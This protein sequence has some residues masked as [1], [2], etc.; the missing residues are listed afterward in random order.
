MNLLEVKQK[1]LN[2]KE[3]NTNDT[4]TRNKI[5]N[6]IEEVKNNPELHEEQTGLLITTE[7]E[8]KEYVDSCINNEI[9]VL[10]L[11]TTGLDCFSDAIVGVCLYTPGE[12]P[13]YI[14]I[15]HTDIENVRLEGQLNED[16]VRSEITR[17]MA[18]PS[19]FIN[20]NIKFDYKFLSKVWGIPVNEEFIFWDTQIGAFLL[21]ENEPT[22]GL[23][24]LYDKYIL[25][26]KATGSKFKDL[27]GNIPFNYIP[28]DIAKVYGAND[29]YKTY[30]LYEFQK[31][32]LDKDHP[33]A[34][35]QKLSYVFFEIEMKLLP[36]IIDIELTGIKLD[37]VRAKE[38][39]H[40]YEGKLLESQEILDRIVDKYLDKISKHPKLEP[41]IAKTGFNLNSPTQL[42]HLLYDI[43]KLPKIDGTSTGKSTLD[44]LLQENIK[45]EYKLFLQ[46]LLDYK[47]NQKLL[48]AF[49][50]KL[51]SEVKEDGCIHGRF[52]AL[53]TATGRFSSNSPN[54]QQIPSR[55]GDIRGM[56][57]AREGNIIIGSDY[58]QIEVRVT[59]SFSKDPTMLHAYETG[60]DLYSKM[61][62]EIHGLPYE[63]CMEFN[64]ITGEL[65]K[66]GKKLRSNTKS[67]LLGLLYGRQA[68]SIGE[69]INVPEKEAQELVDSFFKSF[70][71]IKELDKITKLGATQNGYITTICGRK[72]RL[73]DIKSKDRWTKAR[74]ERQCLNA[75]IQGSSADCMKLAMISI[76][77]NKRLRELNAK[78]VLTVHDEVEIECPV[79]H[80]K[81]VADIMTTI[82]KDIGEN[83]FNIKM[84]C[85]EEFMFR[86]GEP[87]D[88]DNL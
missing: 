20:H 84:K 78:L 64:P 16:Y 67:I 82:M 44:A 53:G 80:A 46:T 18:S 87:I 48:T 7:L 83:L 74:A 68:K 77:N 81:E 23:K 13:C 42:Q 43:W 63:A 8:L 47:Q 22:H 26:K 21:N 57:C 6:K 71:K 17:L 54:L 30:K 86:W 66:E 61:A 58:S 24:P 49:I 39:E 2:R 65:Q 9:F 5:L 37:L 11:E 29:G 51:P 76:H 15:N 36:V 85:D 19:K 32:Y 75:M 45:E 52:N 69:Q 25:R 73:P 10:D 62:S 70:P 28:L 12:K 56:F 1:L 50:Q 3:F 38:L 41:L 14:P 40:K 4:R 34:D 27:F 55:A 35:M 88:I 59:A 79:E 33:R 72:R 60:E 31:Q